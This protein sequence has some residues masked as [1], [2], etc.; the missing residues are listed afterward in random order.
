M[1]E[2]N[3]EIQTTDGACD[4]ILFSADDTSRRPG[5]ILLTDIGG[6]RPANRD[7]ARRIA[8]Q[9]YSVLIP[10]VFY[11]TGRP[12]MLDF[13]PTA[14]DE[15]T[16]K[17]FAELTGPLT[18]DAMERDCG[19]YVDFLAA[20]KSVKGGEMGVVGYCF[21]GAMAMR[22]A[23]TRPEKI[24]AAASFHGGK[25]FTDT[26]TSPHIVLPRIKARLYFGHAIEDN[27]MPAE[28]IAKLNDALKAWGGKYES[29]VYDGA[30][31][32][33]TSTDSPAYNRGQAER[34]FDKLIT[35]F[36]DVLN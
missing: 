23:A 4:G 9:G 26:E 8:E 20:H 18:P 13:K 28:A 21:T 31:H 29:E 7:L 1:I 34:A 16:V 32:S 33:W 5:V 22:M 15:R 19:C 12:P 14:G 10:N 35:L 30:R 6:I 24:A 3:L 11:R 27:S 2:Q 25:L 17:R 36:A